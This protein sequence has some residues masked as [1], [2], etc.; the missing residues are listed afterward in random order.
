MKARPNFYNVTDKPNVRHGKVDCSVDTRCI[1]L[2]DNYHNKRRDMLA[3]IL[4]KF[5]YIETQAKD[6]ISPLYKIS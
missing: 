1:A 6:F 4:V 2:K 5:N 3:Y